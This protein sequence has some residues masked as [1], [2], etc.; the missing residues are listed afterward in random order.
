MYSNFA[1][2]WYLGQLAQFY[3]L[4]P[5]ILSLFMRIG[6]TRA[7]LAIV[8]LCWGGWL[9]YAWCFPA[10]PNAPPDF[11]ENLMHFNL[12][13]RLP[14]FAIGMWLASLR[15]PGAHSMPPNIFKNPFSLF[16]AVLL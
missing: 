3:L 9:F 11:A 10:P 13:G 15:T 2:F 8:A 14:E 16:A 12:P 5:V 7:A 4:F 1:H 6:P